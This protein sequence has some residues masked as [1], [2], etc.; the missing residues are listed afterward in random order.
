MVLQPCSVVFHSF[1]F[2]VDNDYLH[3]ETLSE[4]A[5]VMNVH[6]V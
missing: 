2:S 5:G 3:V 6:E 4:A 1:I